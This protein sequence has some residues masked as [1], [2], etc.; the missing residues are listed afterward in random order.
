[1]HIYIYIYILLASERRARHLQGLHN[2]KSGMFIYLF[3]YMDVRMSFC[4]LTL[5]FLC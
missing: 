4:T 3:I 2:R 1:M 5:A